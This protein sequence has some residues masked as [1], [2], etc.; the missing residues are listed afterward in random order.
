MTST[1]LEALD[2]NRENFYFSSI[3]HLALRDDDD[4]RFRY[5]LIISLITHRI[6]CMYVLELEG[7]H[8]GM[9]MRREREKYVC[10][11]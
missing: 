9:M 2:F 6:K 4:F 1:S 3:F 11:M 5:L 7:R 10:E 8:I